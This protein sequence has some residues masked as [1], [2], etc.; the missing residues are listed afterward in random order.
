MGND[1]RLRDV[2]EADLELFFQK[3]KTRPLY[4]DPFAGNTGSVKLLEKCG[5]QRS[6]TVRHGEDEHIMLVL[7]ADEP[8]LARPSSPDDA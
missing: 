3:E 7:Y 2:E 5:F 4:P 8:P 1:V 6:G